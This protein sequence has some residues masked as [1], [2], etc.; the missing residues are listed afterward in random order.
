MGRDV[1]RAGGHNARGIESNSGRTFTISIMTA[2]ALSSA[3]ER[4]LYS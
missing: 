3:I 4:T 1:L 2:A